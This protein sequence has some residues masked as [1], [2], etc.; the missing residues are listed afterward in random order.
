MNTKTGIANLP[1]DPL[2]VSQVPL[3]T[4][5][6]RPGI[7]LQVRRLVEGASKKEAQL[8]GVIESRG[9]MVGPQG[10]EGDDPALAEGE[11]CIVRGFTGQHEFSFVSKVLQTFQKPF[12]Y[13]LLAYPA[14]VDARQVRQSMRTR[15]SWP[16]T[17]RAGP[18]SQDGQLVDIS[19]QGA[20]VG[21]PQPVA[22]VGASVRLDIRAEF[23]GS[24]VTLSAAATVCHSHKPT[25][26]PVHITGMAFVGL[27][28][29]DKLILH[30]LTKA[31][32]G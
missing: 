19:P 4:L 2:N 5:S 10:S 6:L 11:V 25:A 9:V 8:F 31:P 27:S 32:Q 14:H 1:P 20:M 29:Q 7:A 30:Y 26:S 23:E 17:L 3:K 12:A 28:Q 15:T 16:A 21:T 18:Q 24:P 13:A 22:A